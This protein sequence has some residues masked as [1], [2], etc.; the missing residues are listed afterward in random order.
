MV[1]RLVL[2]WVCGTCVSQ[3]FNDGV[4]I[5]QQQGGAAC[6]AEE[7]KSKARLLYSLGVSLH[8]R[9]VRVIS[10]GCD[11]GDSMT[12]RLC[13]RWCRGAP[14]FGGGGGGGRRCGLVG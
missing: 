5:E 3:E 2:A 11:T 1:V 14:S 13:W 10:C 7:V 4:I 6:S 12:R 8:T 9:L